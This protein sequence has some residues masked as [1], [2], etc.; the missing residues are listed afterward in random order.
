MWAA[1]RT[2]ALLATAVADRPLPAPAPAKG[3]VIAAAHRASQQ[4]AAVDRATKVLRSIEKKATEASR[5]HQRLQR[6]VEKQQQTLEVEQQRQTQ[7]RMDR[8][9]I[10]R[11]RA[12]VRDDSPESDARQGLRS[13]ESTPT[14]RQLPPRQARP[15]DLREDGPQ[16]SIVAFHA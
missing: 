11:Q 2:D 8:D 13:A 4:E 1:S 9:N 5:R 16:I 12:E 10:Q 7:F 3:V 15:A 6:R 14:K